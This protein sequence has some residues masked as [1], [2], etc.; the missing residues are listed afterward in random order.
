[1]SFDSVA[2]QADDPLREAAD[3]QAALAGQGMDAHDRVGGPELDGDE[4]RAAARRFSSSLLSGT[5]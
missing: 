4:L 2:G 1:M 5:A 3:E